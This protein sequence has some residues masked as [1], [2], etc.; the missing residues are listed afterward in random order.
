MSGKT[1]NM[2]SALANA[3]STESPLTSAQ[4][5]NLARIFTY[6]SAKA[7]RGPWVVIGSHDL[8]AMPI[9]DEIL[10]MAAVCGEPDRTITFRDE[11]FLRYELKK[12]WAN[13]VIYAFQQQLK[14]RQDLEEYF[15]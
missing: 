15:R 14:Q 13:Q 3:V 12:A 2:Y 8:L 4:K 1:R 7:D 5:K 6:L 11:K 9:L 10:K